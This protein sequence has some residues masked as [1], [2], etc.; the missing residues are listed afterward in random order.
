[1]LSNTYQ[2][3]FIFKAFGGLLF[4]SAR[5]KC[6]AKN[7]R[8]INLRKTSFT[9]SRFLKENKNLKITEKFYDIEFK[10]NKQTT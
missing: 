4:T 2:L 6:D 3:S 9:R 5:N 10:T 8:K 7:L 1:M